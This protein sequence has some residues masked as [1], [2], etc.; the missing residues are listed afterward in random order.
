MNEHVNLVT[1]LARLASNADEFQKLL[2]EAC[3]AH[4]IDPI[5]CLATYVMRDNVA[6]S[7]VSGIIAM[8]GNYEFLNDRTFL[9]GLQVAAASTIAKMTFKEFECILFKAKLFYLCKKFN[10]KYTPELLSVAKRQDPSQSIPSACPF[11]TRR[12]LVVERPPLDMILELDKD[13]VTVS[14]TD[15]FFLKVA[16]ATNHFA[17]LDKHLLLDERYHSSFG[18]RDNRYCTERVTAV[19]EK[20]VCKELDRLAGYI[21]LNGADM[22]KLGIFESMIPCDKAAQLSRVVPF[23][24]HITGCTEAISILI[25]FLYELGIHPGP[26]KVSLLIEESIKH[27]DMS[28]QEFVDHLRTIYPEFLNAPSCKA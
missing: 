13:T 6:P 25:Q 12:S 22:I 2:Q 17:I 23:V 11:S 15:P 21:N 8:L 28:V 27:S 26:E 16:S 18:P 24:F 4:G 19:L 9:A 10:V 5:K 14:S 7:H 1:E 3:S 20:G